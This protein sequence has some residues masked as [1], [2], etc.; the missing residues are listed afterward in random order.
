[1]SKNTAWALL[2]AF[3]YLTGIGA[4]YN[5]LRA[6]RP[7][8]SSTLLNGDEQNACRFER[9]GDVV[10]SAAWPVTLTLMAGAN[11]AEEARR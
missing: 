3:L 4:T 1:M 9:T 6:G 7:A 2:S 8:C 5:M 11:L 10:A